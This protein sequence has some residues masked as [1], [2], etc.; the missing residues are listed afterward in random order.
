MKSTNLLFILFLFQTLLFSSCS[1]NDENEGE[2]ATKTYFPGK[3][4][5]PFKGTYLIANVNEQ[6]NKVELEENCWTKGLDI[7]EINPFGDAES[8]YYIAFEG[9]HATMYQ[10]TNAKLLSDTLLLIGEPEDE[11][12]PKTVKF[13]LFPVQDNAWKLVDQNNNYY[14]LVKEQ[15]K[16]DYPYIPCKEEVELTEEYLQDRIVETLF[17]LK[18][19]NKNFDTLIP[20]TGIIL[21]TPNAEPGKEDTLFTTRDIINTNIFNTPVYERLLG[22]VQKHMNEEMSFISV[23]DSFPDRCNPQAEGLFI[24]FNDIDNQTADFKIMLTKRNDELNEFYTYL[25]IEFEYDN[26]LYIKSIDNL[27]CG[28]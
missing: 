10:M 18:E 16:K 12:T 28:L 3:E 7:F 19:T 2:N 27:E 24:V 15:N 6:T 26:Q 9:F 14:Y 25:V 22:N 1:E 13:K 4:I 8:G 21:K 17:A 23:D 20:P 11:E 5:N